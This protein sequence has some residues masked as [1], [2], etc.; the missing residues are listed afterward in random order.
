MKLLI[1]LLVLSQVAIAQ[2]RSSL[3]LFDSIGRGDIEVADFD[4]DSNLDL[5]MT[6]LSESNGE[7]MKF[8]LNDGSSNFLE[9]IDSSF[10][11]MDNAF[12]ASGDLDGDNDIDFIASGRDASNDPRVFML[13]NDGNGS[14]TSSTSNSFTQTSGAVSLAD[15][16][17]DNDLD[18]L[19]IGDDANFNGVVELYLNDGSGSFSSQ[20][21][22]FPQARAGANPLF[23]DIDGDND[24]D[25]LIL[26]GISLNKKLYRNDGFGNFTEIAIGD[27]DNLSGNNLANTDVDGDGDQDLIAGGEAGSVF[28]KLYLNDGNGLFTESNQVLPGL[29]RCSY[30]FGDLDGDSD[31]DLIMTGEDTAFSPFSAIFFNDGSGNFTNSGQQFLACSEGDIELFDVDGDNDLDFIIT[32]WTAAFNAS[33]ALYI[34]DGSGNFNLISN[35]HESNFRE[36]NSEVNIYPNPSKGKLFVDYPDN[37][38]IQRARIITLTGA[39]MI[40]ADPSE[41]RKGINTQSLKAGM[42]H[43][44]LEGADFRQE[45]RFV[46]E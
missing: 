17:G 22:P 40:L 13:V 37:L 44:V 16:D 38:E 4:G 19:T 8:Y 20:T 10:I 24:Q 1:T 14:F 42:Y 34:N 43:L 9:L 26:D 41:L 3:I 39:E 21:T 36:I 33:S 31:P 25:L 27:I 12:T 7:I 35:L 46:T 28:T 32:G 5:I 15:V 18:L 2:N 11:S 6:G 23:F 29:R 45:L 30:T